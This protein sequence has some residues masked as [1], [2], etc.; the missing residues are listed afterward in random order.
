MR[1]LP[2]EKQVAFKIFKWHISVYFLPLFGERSLFSILTLS[3]CMQEFC[4]A[5]HYTRLQCSP[6]SMTPSFYHKWLCCVLVPCCQ[7]SLCLLS[8]KFTS[9]FTTL[10]KDAWANSPTVK[11]KWSSM[12]SCNKCRDFSIYNQYHWKIQ[13]IQW[14]CWFVAL[15]KGWKQVW[16]TET[17]DPP[18]CTS[19]KTNMIV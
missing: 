7:S 9:H 6:G 2:L 15:L 4:G 3:N 8:L 10:L 12:H 18:G 14:N 11:E 19:L 17:F 5:L 16:I 13:R 1:T